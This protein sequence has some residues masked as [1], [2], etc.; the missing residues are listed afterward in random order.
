[1]IERV[2]YTQNGKV[3]AILAIQ[4]GA[5]KHTAVLMMEPDFA[6]IVAKDVTNAAELA[7]EAVKKGAII[8]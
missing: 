6:R 8:Q 4:I 5:D 3:F 2:G 1:M 7:E